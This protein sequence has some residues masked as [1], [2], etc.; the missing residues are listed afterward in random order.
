MYPQNAQ[1]GNCEFLMVSDNQPCGHMISG[2]YIDTKVFTSADVKN[3]LCVNRVMNDFGCVYHVEKE[4]GKP[5]LFY[6]FKR[7][8]DYECNTLRYWIGQ[9]Q[10]GSRQWHV[11]QNQFNGLVLLRERMISPEWV[12]QF[13]DKKKFDMPEAKERIFK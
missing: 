12:L 1:L 8:L 10:P 9:C 2:S 5:N 3:T 7:V 11:Y 6:A 13:L 4:D